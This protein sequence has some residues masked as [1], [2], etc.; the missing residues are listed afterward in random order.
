MSVVVVVVLLRVEFIVVI[1][2]VAVGESTFCVEY[3]TVELDGATSTK[4]DCCCSVVVVDALVDP[5]LSIC[6]LKPLT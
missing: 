2:V 4:S 5:K 1:V 3:E 6:P